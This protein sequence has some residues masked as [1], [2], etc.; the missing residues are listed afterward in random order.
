MAFNYSFQLY[1]RLFILVSVVLTFA[2]SQVP[3]PFPLDITFTPDTD[4]TLTN[5]AN[6]LSI[7]KVKSGNIYNQQP[8]K[9]VQDPAAHSHDVEE[10]EGHKTST[11][12]GMHLDT[13]GQVLHRKSARRRAIGFYFVF[14]CGQAERCRRGKFFFLSFSSVILPKKRKKERRICLF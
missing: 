10:E 12:I 6:K 5:S 1:V 3:V 11:A 4:L 13:T 14:T 7:K 2:S 9:V 8:V